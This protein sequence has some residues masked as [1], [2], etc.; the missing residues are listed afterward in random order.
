MMKP[1]ALDPER[2]KRD[3]INATHDL[4]WPERVQR[5]QEFGVELVIGER[6]GY[7]IKDLDG[8]GFWDV[9]LNGGTF[10]LGHRNPDLV[11]SLVKAVEFYDIGNHHFSSPV[12]VDLAA[13]L[14][15]T[16]PSL[17]RVIYGT[18]GS[19]AI[20]IAIKCA[21]FATGRRK[22]ASISQAYHGRTGLSGAAG[23]DASAA[24]FN[25]DRPDDF[26]KFD[27]N[28]PDSVRSVFAEHKL[29]AVLLEVIPATYGF[30]VPSS[31]FLDAIRDGCRNSGALLIADEVQTGLMRSGS[32]WCSHALGLEPDLIVTS[33]GLSGGLYPIA[34]VI[35]SEAASDWTAIDGWAHVSTFAGSEVGCEVARKVLSMT[36]QDDTVSRVRRNIAI[37]S[38]ELG[39]LC[40]R[41]AALQR[42]RQTG[43]IIGL[44]TDRPDGG[45]ELMRHLSESG[46]WAIF[47]NFD[48]KTLQ[49][50]PGLLLDEADLA[51][52]FA[53]LDAALRRMG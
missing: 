40:E 9:H 38:E 25:S 16:A 47:A 42:V 28:D 10:N 30:P 11:E 27:F 7:K 2:Q 26:V 31:A 6:T 49:F 36:Q 8:R 20:D 50:K 48:P 43:L 39:M 24:F 37:L 52:I 18:S 32:L 53:R 33:K 41:H 13:R 4:M 21:R 14:L 46:V 35:A 15:E 45:I 51:D 23:N 12:R 19:E 34:A 22:I 1:T 44:E 17:S 5:W 3:A 29:A